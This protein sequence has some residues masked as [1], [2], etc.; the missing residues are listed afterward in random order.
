MRGVATFTQGKLHG[1]PFWKENH[2]D[3]NGERTTYEKM[4]DGKPHGVK[5]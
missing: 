4:I 3:L 5:R 2:F 1:G